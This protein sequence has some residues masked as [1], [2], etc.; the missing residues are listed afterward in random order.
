ML[1]VILLGTVFKETVAVTAFLFFFTGMG[2]RRRLAYFG[3]A[4]VGC[5]L[6]K[7]WITYAVFGHCQLSTAEW[8][9]WPRL[10]HVY[11]DNN[12]DGWHLRNCLWLNGGTAM[13]ALF[14]LPMKTMVDR[15]TKCILAI[16]FLGE[17]L[18]G[19]FAEF[20]DF[21]EVIPMSMLYL[22]RTLENWRTSKVG[23]SPLPSASVVDRRRGQ[24]LVK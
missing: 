3:A 18:A 4:A 15:A 8:T 19:D 2:W 7:L 6:L 12:P 23:P 22:A 10:R 5:L 14:V 11:S 9:N 16:F 20:R 1:P 21:L 13:V 17:L 24:R